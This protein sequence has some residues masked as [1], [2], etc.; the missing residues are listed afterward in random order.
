[1]ANSPEP[2]ILIKG[3]LAVDDRGQ[4]TFANVFSFAGIQRFYMVENF[5]T[6]VIR[7]FHGHLRENKFVFV[8]AVKVN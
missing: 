8:A 4:L 2:P 1:M 6:E 5:S 7:A 3:G